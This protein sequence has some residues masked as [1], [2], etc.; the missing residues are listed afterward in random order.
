MNMIHKVSAAAILLGLGG[1]FSFANA[2]S[3]SAL[4]ELLTQKQS[5]D[6]AVSINKSSRD[7]WRVGESIKLHVTSQK[8]CNLQM[9]H[10][11]ANGVAAVFELGKIKAGKETTFPKGIDFM[12]VEPPLGQ[13]SIYVVCSKRKMPN[14][15]KL[16]VPVV[17]NVVEAEH[18]EAMGKQYV[19]KLGK[20][21]LVSKVSYSVMGRNDEIAL[22]SDDIVGFYTTRSRTIQRPKLDLNVNFDFRSAELNDDS[23]SFLDEVGKALND[24]RMLGTKFELNGHTDD[25]G[26]DEYN[27]SLSSKR[28]VAVGQYLQSAHGVEASR[29]IPKGYGE[30]L[31]KVENIDDET[32]AENRRVEFKLIRDL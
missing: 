10:L 30:A 29:V 27:L 19:S 13:D 21:P 6:L 4:D 18:V 2:S 24:Q 11:D 16:S 26:S 5:S 32:R 7:Q 1:M 3:I 20:K 25:I 9:I 8:S 28:A 31:P 17:E 15:A 22:F 23:K 12:S 14:L